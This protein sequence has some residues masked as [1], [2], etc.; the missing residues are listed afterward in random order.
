MAKKGAFLRLDDP[1]NN[2]L[3]KDAP[4]LFKTLPQVLSD[5]A[6]VQGAAGMGV[7][8][9]PTYKEIAQQDVWDINTTL[10]AK[11]GYTAADITDFYSL[12]PVLAKIKAGEGKDFYPI[13]TDFTVWERAV[14]N[15]DM[16]DPYNLL[17]YPFD[18]V[19]P[20]KSG[21]TIRSAFESA[22]MQKFLTTEHDYY[23][24]GYINPAAATNT[25]DMNQTWT[26]TM[27]SG[28]WAVGIYPYYPGYEYTETSTYGY[29]CEVKP[30]Q[31]GII[32]TTS[33]R[34][35]MNAIY[36]GSKNADAS[37]KVIN[38]INT[39]A[40]FRTLL[41]FGIEG[42]HYTKGTDGKITFTKEKDNY[43]VWAAGLGAITLLPLQEGQPD[44]LYTELFPKFDSAQAVPILGFALDQDP[45]K[46]QMA[47]L[48]NIETQY[49]IPL[50]TG[51]VDPATKLPEFIT[52]LKAN[53][54]DDVVKAV[55]EQ[56]AAFLAAKGK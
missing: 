16:V 19:N 20:S 37:L 26:D 55:N 47:A 39:D 1:S 5:A 4:D 15:V 8:A 36:S 14:R 35:A 25:K 38:L 42:T 45:I 23:V 48:Q 11:Y 50:I 44:N 12:G 27:K 13:N 49:E 51:S 7:Y 53:G 9:I 2:L 3:Q 54:I 10:L 40:T 56:V 24:K 18:P 21:T 17:D 33:A 30:V 32:S 41:T 52:Q 22:D 43:G 6:M 31:A 34:G 28:K 46:T 29:K